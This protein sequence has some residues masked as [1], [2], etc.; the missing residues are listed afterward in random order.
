MKK[1]IGNVVK[2]RYNEVQISFFQKFYGRYHELVDRSA[3]S[4]SQKATD[5]LSR[6][7]S[8]HIY[9]FVYLHVMAPL[10]FSFMDVP[11]HNFI[12]Y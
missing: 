2:I 1:Y 11:G 3:I 7:T 5:L 6:L 8:K 4:V 9:L 12:D 10:V